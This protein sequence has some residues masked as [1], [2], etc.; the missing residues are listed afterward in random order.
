[1]IFIDF[2]LNESYIAEFLCINKEE[3]ITVCGGNC[4][5]SKKIKETQDNRD[6]P[7][8]SN[9]KLKLEIV[10]SCISRENFKLQ[11]LKLGKEGLEIFEFRD[12]YDY[13]SVSGIFHPP[14]LV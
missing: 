6:I 11:Q 14:Q 3:P 12:N 10:Y 7:L 13:L 5:L 4:Y 8:S 1:M 9:S 2:K